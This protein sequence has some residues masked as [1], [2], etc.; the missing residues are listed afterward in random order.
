MYFCGAKQ[1][2][3]FHLSDDPDSTCLMGRPRDSDSGL[4][5]NRWVSQ[6]GRLGGARTGREILYRRDKCLCFTY[7]RQSPSQFLPP[8]E[9]PTQHSAFFPLFSVTGDST[10]CSIFR[11]QNRYLRAINHLLKICSSDVVKAQHAMFL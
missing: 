7:R 9:F 10:L 3:L 2:T 1:H 8:R 6:D 4:S 5:V 11:S